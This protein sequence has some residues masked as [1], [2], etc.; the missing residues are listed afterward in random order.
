MTLPDPVQVWCG[1]GP[2][3]VFPG[4][5]MRPCGRFGLRVTFRNEREDDE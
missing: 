1:C 2:T 5:P 3:W 4:Y